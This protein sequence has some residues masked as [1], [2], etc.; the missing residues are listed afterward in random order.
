MRI[1]SMPI[2]LAGVFVASGYAVVHQNLRGLFESEGKC[3]MFATEIADGYDTVE[4]IARPDHQ[5]Q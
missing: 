5:Q 4:W 2:A 3:Q 1:C